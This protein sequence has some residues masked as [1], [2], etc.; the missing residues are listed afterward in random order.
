VSGLTAVNQGSEV[1]LSWEWSDGP[2][3]FIVLR[4]N[5]QVGTS[6]DLSFEDEPLIAGATSYTITPVVE[7]QTLLAGSMTITDFDV[8]ISIESNNQ[9]SETGGFVLGLIF[10]ISSFAVIS[11]SLLERRK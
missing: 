5:E 1:L 8:S 4:N 6:T 7:N 3:D 10:I 9:V 2:A 11:L